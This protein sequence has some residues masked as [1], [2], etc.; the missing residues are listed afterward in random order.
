[1]TDPR[2]TPSQRRLLD[3]I[4]ATERGVLYIARAG[5]RARTINALAAKGL[6][7]NVEPDHPNDAMDGW[8][9]SEPVEHQ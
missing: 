1:M 5:R 9:I 3:D 6:V 8:A 4:R 7:R 2:I